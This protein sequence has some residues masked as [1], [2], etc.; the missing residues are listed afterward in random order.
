MLEVTVDCVQTAPTLVLN[1]QTAQLYVKPFFE[2]LPQG[3]ATQ[4]Q[5]SCWSRSC[6]SGSLNRPHLPKQ[7]S[8]S[9]IR[10]P[11]A[12]SQNTRG[13][14]TAICSNPRIHNLTGNRKKKLDQSSI[15]QHLNMLLFFNKIIR[16]NNLWWTAFR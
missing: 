11:G 12:S 15:D 10:S 1:I 14:W 13:S 16:T 3:P 5:W 2:V 4:A 6:D 7:T 8:Q 9:A